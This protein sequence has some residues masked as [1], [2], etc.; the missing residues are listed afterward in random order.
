MY[1]NGKACQEVQRRIRNSCV[2]NHRY[3]DIKPPESRSPFSRDLCFFRPPPDA[4][5][6]IEG[7]ELLL[8]YPASS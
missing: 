6:F 2:Q 4:A 1:R 5:Q 8:S 7:S 3:R